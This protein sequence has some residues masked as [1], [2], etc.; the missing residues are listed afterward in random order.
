MNKKIQQIAPLL[1]T[2]MVVALRPG[3]SQT[4]P[5]SFTADNSTVVIAPG[6]V[7]LRLSERSYFGP[8]SRW[9]IH[10][11]LEI[12]SKEIWIAPTAEFTGT[13]R[14]IIHDPGTNP[15]YEDMESAPTVIDGNNGTPIGVAVE[16]RN[17]HNLVLGDIADPGYGM[18]NP[19]GSRAAALHLGTLFEFAVDGGDIILGG[20]DLLLGEHARL[21]GY[22][23][24]RMVVTGNSVS[25]HIVKTHGNTQPVVFPVGIMEGDYTPAT[26]APQ[27]AATL[28]VSVQDYE[29][30]GITLPD[31]EIGMD[32]I[33]HIFADNG[34]NAIYTLQH[35]MVT[36]GLLYV[37]ETAEIVQYAGG[38]NWI[39]DVTVL[40]GEG[41]HRRADILM[42]TGA[43]QDGRWLTKF[44]YTADVGPEAADDMATVAS[45]SS[46]QIV[47]LENDEPGSS[48]IIAGDT[49]I[50]R[51]PANGTATV[52]PDGSITYTPNA[53]FVG[54]ET[55]EYEI[56]DENGL[57]SRATVTVTVTARTLRIPNVFTPNGDGVNDTWEIEGLE[58]ID[59][60]EVVVVNRW[61]NEVYRSTDYRNDW[62]GGNLNEGTYYYSITTHQGNERTQYKGWVLVKRQ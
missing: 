33:W 60:L 6:T 30:A 44:H 59:R 62:D 17:P 57:T 12:W 22:G 43:L 1:L 45:G 2:I 31:A 42:A 46:V 48:P 19:V 32:R 3:Y 41:I 34:V 29:A 25:G 26:L 15:F 52:N 56:V 39:G 61:G 36:N 21:E 37:D 38:T 24:Q 5:G 35:N 23:P 40:E 50:T 49:R 54:T 58:G 53:G 27:S 11:T 14:I 18:E 20:H 47:A 28:Y 8:N 4:S 7:E 10:G 13:G 9:E 55:F 16:L 51:Q